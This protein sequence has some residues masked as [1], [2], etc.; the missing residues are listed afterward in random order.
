MFLIMFPFFFHFS[1]L[2]LKYSLIYPIFLSHFPY[3]VPIV[4]M[5]LLNLFHVLCQMFLTLF[6]WFPCPSFY[7]IFFAQSPPI[8]YSIGGSNGKPTLALC[9]TCSTFEA[10]FF[11]DGPIN[12]AY[13]WK[14]WF[15]FFMIHNNLIRIATYY[16]LLGELQQRD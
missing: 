14:K 7:P 3:V 2:V 1:P 5:W 13:H 9:W 4:P 10:C 16:F 15:E 8:T 11:Y 6:T 12:E